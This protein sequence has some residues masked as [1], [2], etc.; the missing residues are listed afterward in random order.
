MGDLQRCLAS[1]EYGMLK[2]CPLFESNFMQV[3]KTGDVANRVTV[4]IAATSPS[5]ELPDLML[6]ARPAPSLTGQCLCECPDPEAFPD[7]ELQLFGLLPLK[8]VRIYVHDETRFQFKVR[9]ANG[10]TFYLQLLTHPLKQEDVFGQWVRLL[11]RLRF[12]H[13]DAPLTYEQEA[14]AYRHQK[15]RQSTPE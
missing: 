3:T 13:S 2:D 10:R 6:L 14:T 9:L 7:E 8:F 1:G 12:H 11:Y 5:L 15:R 4:G